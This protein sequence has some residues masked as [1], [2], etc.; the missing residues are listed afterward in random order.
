MSYGSGY[1]QQPH[2]AAAGT[3]QDYFVLDNDNRVI[4]VSSAGLHPN[5][6]AAAAAL[7]QQQ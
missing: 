6:A 1:E 3:N 2:Y 7:M 4:L 5:T